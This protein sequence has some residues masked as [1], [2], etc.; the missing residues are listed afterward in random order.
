VSSHYRTPAVA[1]WTVSLLSVA[2]VVHT[3]AYS[4]ITGACT[5]FLYISYVIP[6]ALGLATFGRSWTRM[7]PW[8]LGGPLYRALA[9]ISIVGC[10]LILLIGVQPPN[11]QNL[12]TVLIALAMTALVWAVYERTHFRGPPPAVLGRGNGPRTEAMEVSTLTS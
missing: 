8:N 4:T 11:E 2:F 10:G 6:T 7:G 12:W 3:R 5:I 1:I 9:M